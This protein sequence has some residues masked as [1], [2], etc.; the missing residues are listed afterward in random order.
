MPDGVRGGDLHLDG[1]APLLCLG[2][3]VGP[4]L[5]PDLHQAVHGLQPE[6][7]YVEGGDE[8]LGEASEDGAGLPDAA[9]ELGDAGLRGLQFLLVGGEA[10]GVVHPLHLLAE[11]LGVL[12]QLLHRHLLHAQ[13]LGIGVA[14]L[15]EGLQG[16]DVGV[17]GGL[18][19]LEL[20]GVLLALHPHLHQS[21]VRLLDAGAG[22]V[23]R[24][25]DIGEGCLYLLRGLLVQIDP[26]GKGY[27][28]IFYSTH[29]CAVYDSAQK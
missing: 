5:L 10:L 12:L 16:L 29:I 24:A 20:R 1:I 8:T 6:G 13:L 7:D 21:G 4:D 2:L 28:F 22:L 9:A 17:Q 18:Q 3:E 14:L 23:G 26:C 19:G 25:V 11:L 15:G 27:D